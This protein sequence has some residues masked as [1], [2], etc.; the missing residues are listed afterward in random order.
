[1]KEYILTLCAAAIIL[2]VTTC[3]LSEGALKK[4]A[5]MASSVMISL[6]I[7]LPFAKMLNKDFEIAMP[8]LGS[9][10]D[11]TDASA[12][13]NKMLKEEYKKEIEKS[14]SYLGRAYAYVSDELEVTKIEIYA[15]NP[16]GKDELDKINEEY[17]PW[18]TEVYYE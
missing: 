5:I 1:M 17:A 2:S 8:D 4:Y 16:I 3:I 14:L 9:Y 15:T 6:A 12:E 10:H 13:Y 18:E 7:A 11:G